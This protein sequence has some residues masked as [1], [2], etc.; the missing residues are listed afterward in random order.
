M[1][2]QWTES[3]YRIKTLLTIAPVL[4]FLLIVLICI[5]KSCMN[6]GIDPIDDS[7]ISSRQVV[8]H[9]NVLDSTFNGFRVVYATKN[10]VTG[11]RLK[12][13]RNREHI[14]T[15]FM[16]LQNDAPVYFGGSLLNTDIYDFAGFAVQYDCD[17]DIEMHNI[18]VA[19]HQK[20]A[21]YIGK[22]FRIDRPAQFFD[23]RTEQGILYLS[24]DDIYY[25][26]DLDR[27]I[28]RYWKCYGNNQ[29][30]KTDEHFSHFSEDERIW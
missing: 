19:G 27:R 9:L 26:R 1:A 29:T 16:H 2:K 3:E 25:R 14:R 11:L 4:F 5:V 8:E 23:F 22:N 12:E 30:S 6:S 10:N 18:F 24:H 7:I 28:Y 20:S 21:L 15:A 17:P 13:I